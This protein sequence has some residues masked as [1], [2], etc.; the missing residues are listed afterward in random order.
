MIYPCN[1]KNHPEAARK[2]PD[3]R[4]QNSEEIIAYIHRIQVN[5]IPSQLPGRW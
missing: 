5:N 3:N 4:F 2:N 1:W